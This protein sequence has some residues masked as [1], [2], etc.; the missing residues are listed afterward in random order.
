MDIIQ[1]L[2][3]LHAL[4]QKVIHPHFLDD[5]KLVMAM[6]QY[7]LWNDMAL[8][9]GL[10]SH[11]QLMQK[12]EYFIVFDAIKKSVD[13]HSFIHL[14]NVLQTASRYMGFQL[15]ERIKKVGHALIDL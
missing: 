10:F 1:S 14:K 6:H 4:A 15:V 2:E 5:N 3:M 13:N 7:D 11:T 8:V 12:H 9:G